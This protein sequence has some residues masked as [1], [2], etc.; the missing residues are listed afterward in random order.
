MLTGQD[1]SYS[2]SQMHMIGS[3]TTK[4]L[5]EDI[6]IKNNYELV[7]VKYHSVMNSNFEEKI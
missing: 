2:H 3:K 5:D 6:K 7:K 4:K 1:K